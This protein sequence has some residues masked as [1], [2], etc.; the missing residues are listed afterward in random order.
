MRRAALLVLLTLP[1]LGVAQTTYTAQTP[2]TY[3]V[4]TPTSPNTIGFL[5][6]PLSPV[7]GFINLDEC[8]N[9]RVI[10]L[11]WLIQTYETNF[12]VAN[13]PGGRFIVYVND[14]STTTGVNTGPCATVNGD[15]NVAALHAGPV[16]SAITESL[17]D[18]SLGYD[19]DTSAIATMAGQGLCNTPGTDIMV[20]VQAKDSSGNNIGEARVKLTVETTSPGAP[21]NPLASGGNEALNVSWGDPN[22]STSAKSYVIDA[23][24]IGTIIDP[25]PH[26]FSPPVT[27]TDYR[28]GGLVNGQEYEVS[29]FSYSEAFNPSVASTT[30]GTPVPTLDFWN[31]YKAQGGRDSG[32]CASGPAGLLALAAVGGI[33][34][35]AR[36]RR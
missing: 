19:F 1:V 23:A 26:H 7:D 20:C 8:L 10:T 34:A 3:N 9:P 33:L 13:L 11:R 4:P 31:N 35:L 14:Q 24:P 32:G 2:P 18:P 28:L 27:T 36:R 30:T 5:T 21:L 17:Q 25:T 29:V 22:S 6:L 15:K 12:S 16:G